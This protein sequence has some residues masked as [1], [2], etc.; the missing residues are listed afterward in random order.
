MFYALPCRY[1]VSLRQQHKANRPNTD[2]VPYV[3]RVVAGQIMM[4]E[5][6]K[7]CWG[8]M[9]ALDPKGAIQ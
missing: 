4:A 7:S 3:R 9:K 8:W 6:Y 2:N 5:Y 1:S